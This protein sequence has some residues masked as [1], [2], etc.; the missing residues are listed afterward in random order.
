MATRPEDRDATVPPLQEILARTLR[1]EV[2]DLLQTVYSTVAILQDRIG[3]QQTLEKRLLSDLRARAETCKNELDAVHDLVCPLSV[4]PAQTDLTELVGGLVRVFSGRFS[5]LQVHFEAP[6]PLPV[7]VDARR[8]T[9]VGHLLLLSSFQAS[10]KQTWVR[11]RRR[12]ENETEWSI[13]DDGPGASPEQLLWLERPFATT[14]QAL[15]G[16]GAALARRVVEQHG[17]RIE[18]ENSS[19]GGFRITLVLPSK[20]TPE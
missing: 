15:F 5:A 14:H 10:Q 4:R 6:G 12:S 16:L 7:W 19:E 9:H 8:L 1:H 17:G 11:L 3:S 18:A 2:G 13:Q 20:P